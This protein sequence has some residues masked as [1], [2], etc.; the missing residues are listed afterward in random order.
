[1]ATKL[2][3]HEEDQV[4]LCDDMLDGLNWCGRVQHDSSLDS[5][6][7]DL[8]HQPNSSIACAVSTKMTKQKLQNL[9]G[10]PPQ[11]G[12]MQLSSVLCI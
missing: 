9:F 1:M 11:K 4:D 6:V 2:T 10:E 3:A 5:Q 8:H 12:A 7:L